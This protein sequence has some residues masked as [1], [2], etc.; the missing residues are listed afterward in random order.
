VKDSMTVRLSMP[1]RYV[2]TVDGRI[3]DVVSWGETI[4]DVMNDADLAVHPYDRLIVNDI[5]FSMGD[6]VPTPVTREA[7]QTFRQAAWDRVQADPLRIQV[8]RS[9]PITVDD[10]TLPFEIYY[11]ADRGRSAPGGG[12]S[13]LSWRR[14]ST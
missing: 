7:A 14:R 13:G 8:I 5:E 9:I 6:G 2:V 12:D 11:S 10:G 4:G 3:M 1:A